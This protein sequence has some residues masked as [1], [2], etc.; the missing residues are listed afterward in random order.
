MTHV[1]IAKKTAAGLSLDVDFP[2]G[3]GVTAVV[4]PAG[5]GKTL[6]LDLIAGL[7]TP[8]AGRILLN[9]A[10]LFDAAALVDV[11]PRR[12]GIG[13]VFQDS[14]LFPH[15]TLERNVAFAAYAWPRLERHRRVGEMLERFDLASAAALRPEQA[16]AVQRLRCTVARALIAEPKLLLIDDAGVAEA[17]LARIRES[18]QNPIVL[19]T[20]DL[21][22]CAASASQLM[23]LEAGRIVQRG[24]PREVLDAPESIEAARLLGIPNIFEATIVTLDP[25]RKSSRLEFAGFTLAGP[26]IPGHF[27]GDRVWIAVRPEALRVHGKAPENSENV[28]ETQLVR[29]CERVREV[30]LEFTGGIFA[31]VAREEYLRLKDSK[32]WRVEFPA[33]SLRV[34]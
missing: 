34:L 23:L 3:P 2:I 16:T 5:A 14:A 18:F 15:L 25:G 33:E 31:D 1:R 28:V 8:D 7:A 30:R 27:R 12:R 21:D 10:I 13:Y 6:V 17:V 24:A 9:D 4:G 22:I 26:Y 32:T 29:V 20:G 19:V 11:P